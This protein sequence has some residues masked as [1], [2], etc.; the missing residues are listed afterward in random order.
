MRR[1]RLGLAVVLCAIFGAAG[2]EAAPSLPSSGRPADGL[3]DDAE[4]QTVVELGIQRDIDGVVERLLAE[5][6]EVRARA[7]MTLASFQAAESVVALSPLLDD[8]EAQVRRDAAFALGRIGDPGSTG[9]LGAALAEE[10]DAGVRSHLIEALG[11]MA[12]ERAADLLLSADLESWEEAARASSLSVLGGVYGVS[13]EGLRDYLI[14]T[15]THE[16]PSIRLAASSFFGLQSGVRLWARHA[17]YVR[18]ALDSYDLADPAAMHLVVGLARLDDFLDY[19]RL[20]RWAAQAQDWRTRA[21][22]MS[23]LNPLGSAVQ[24]LVDALADP[25]PLVVFA[26]ARALTGGALDDSLVPLLERWIEGHPNRLAVSRELL[27]QLALMRQIDVVL[28]WVDATAPGDERRWVVGLEVLSY[29]PGQESLSRIA[30]AARDPSERTAAE[31]SLVLLR[32]WQG[33]RQ[34]AEAHD[35]YFDLFREL[36]DDPRASV[37]AAARQGLESPEFAVRSFD[38]AALG[39]T[40]APTSEAQVK[41]EPSLPLLPDAQTIDWGFLRG[42]GNAPSLVL[43]TTR[44]TVTLQLL[45]AEAPLTVQTVARL[46]LDG[47]YDGV[48]FHRVLPNF[49]A[50]TGDIVARDGTGEP[51]FTIRTELTQLPFEAGVVGM[52]NLGSLDSENS[53]FFITHSRQPHLARGFTAFGWVSS[54]MDVVDVLE[55]LDAILSAT[56]VPG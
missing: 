14:E 56:V 51:G 15:L 7:A 38:L 30:R 29:I 1:P 49:M 13:H 45:T 55:P 4:L 6:P 18:Q 46:A 36:I 40:S 42:L 24:V 44:G 17:I 48:P 21:N 10:A 2:C 43:E 9:A 26:A 31:A 20:S 32:R 37:A 23:G 41:D 34:S 19:G 5:R 27:I 3:L 35:L 39:A 54:G 16:D 22:A 33:D 12:T 52:A 25:S 28:A 50:Q 53:Q 8:A 11:H 47:H